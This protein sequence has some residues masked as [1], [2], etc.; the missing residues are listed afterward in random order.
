MGVLDFRER[1]GYRRAEPTARGEGSLGLAH[2]GRIKLGGEVSTS[3]VQ[4]PTRRKR[5]GPDLLSGTKEK[6]K[7]NCL[8]GKRGRKVLRGIES[9]RPGTSRLGGGIDR[10]G[11]RGDTTLV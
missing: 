1:V 4:I 7:K 3:K 10:S 2:L 9:K 5:K 8:S 6:R 11:G